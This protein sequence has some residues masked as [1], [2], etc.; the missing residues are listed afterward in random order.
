M[1]W[2]RIFRSRGRGIAFVDELVVHL[3]NFFCREV[4]VLA[5][6]MSQCSLHC[7]QFSIPSFGLHRNFLTS[8]RKM[9]HPS[10]SLGGQGLGLL[11]GTATQQSTHV[12]SRPG[13]SLISQPIRPRSGCWVSQLRRPSP[14]PPS[15]HRRL[16]R[17]VPLP[18]RRHPGGSR[19]H[20]GLRR[21]GTLCHS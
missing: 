19:H 21:G 5:R 14:S 13:Y 7:K 15:S 20:F 4:L 6:G 16:T 3:G 12:T 17:C 18:R 8:K 9:K 10:R 1:S 11:F 2:W